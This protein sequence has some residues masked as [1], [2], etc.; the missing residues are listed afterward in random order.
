[1]NTPGTPEYWKDIRKRIFLN[2]LAFVFGNASILT[3]LLLVYYRM[4]LSDSDKLLATV[5]IVCFAALSLTAVFLS[6]S[7]LLTALTQTILTRFLAHQAKRLNE[8]EDSI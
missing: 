2:F 1:M 3:T 7:L 8:P 4:P 6:I 5:V